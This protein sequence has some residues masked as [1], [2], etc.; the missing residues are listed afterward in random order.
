MRTH[1]TPRQLIVTAD[2][3]GLSEGINASTQALHAEGIITTA[4]V[5]MNFA[6]TEDALQ[7]VHNTPTLRAGVHLNLTDGYPL[8]DIDPDVGLI[9]HDGRFQSRALLFPRA[10]FPNNTWRDAVEAEMIAQIEAFAALSG[11]Q[12]DHLTTHMHFHIVPALRDMVIGLAESY[13]ISWVRA[14]E[15][16]STVLPFNFL[17]QEPAELFQPDNLKITPDYITSIQAWLGQNP[18]RLVETLLGLNGLIEIVVHPDTLDDTTYPPTMSHK[19]DAR[20]KERDY[21][22]RLAA[23]IAEREGAFTLHD[24]A[25]P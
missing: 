2:D 11:R 25:Q 22:L 3:C 6:A 23:L 17:T 21:L 19:P 9:H 18:E 16:F 14:F 1:D 5:M 4:T 15:P 10:M 13:G 7:M 8:T 24:P 12:P 20:A